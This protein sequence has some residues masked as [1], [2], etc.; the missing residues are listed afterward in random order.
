VAHGNP[1]AYGYRIEFEGGAA[2]LADGTLDNLRHLIQMNVAGDYF[3]VA[4]GNTDE[5]FVN[6][7]VTETAGVKQAPVR[8]PLEAF[9]YRVASHICSFL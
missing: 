3:A 5:W 1:I 4:V 2:G 6:I 9:F 8:R 7:G